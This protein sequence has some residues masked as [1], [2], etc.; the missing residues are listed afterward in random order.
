[1][2]R[3]FAMLM[4]AFLMFSMWLQTAEKLR[5]N[6]GGTPATQ[7]ADSVVA[8]VAGEAITEKQVLDAIT[9]LSMQLAAQ[10]QATPEQI[11]QKDTVFFRE[12]LDNLIGTILLKNEARGNNLVADK[13]KIDESLQT[14]K[15]RFGDDAKFQQALQQQGMTEADVRRSIET[16]ILCQQMLERISKNLPPPTDAEIKKY[17]DDNPKSFQA[18]EQRHAAVISL[19]VEKSATPE[20]KAAIRKRMESIRADIES[21]KITFAEAAMKESDDKANSAKGGDVGFV[22][23]GMML[24]LFEDALFEAPAGSLTPILESEIGYH[25]I[26]VIEV[27]P[28]GIVSLDTAKPKIK[29][30]LAGKAKQEATRKHLEELRANAKIETVMSVEEWNKRHSAK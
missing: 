19:K 18:P 1:M 13:A 17:Y 7:T 27:K 20:E 6:A 9:Q 24:K 25:L 3:R 5:Q 8:R 28:A 29:D 11:Q 26:Q 4:L 22:R 10:K 12:A 30:F 16:D 21:K 2:I 15:A 14:M 23:R